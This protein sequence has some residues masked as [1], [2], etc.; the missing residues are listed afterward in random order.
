MLCFIERKGVL[1]FV[2]SRR[3]QGLSCSPLPAKAALFPLQN[4]FRRRYLNFR[5]SCSAIP[6]VQGA[7]SSIPSSPPSV[8]GHI[9]PFP[10][11]SAGSGSSLVHNLSPLQR[12]LKDAG[13]PDWARYDKPHHAAL[14]TEAELVEF[15]SKVSSSKSWC[16]Q[17]CGL[18]VCNGKGPQKISLCG[19]SCCWFPKC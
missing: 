2:G 12:R 5:T 7:H 10:A 16:N 4:I 15:V 6:A 3:V 11:S 18:H 19:S 13:V 8:M 1:L 14:S 9:T 17:H